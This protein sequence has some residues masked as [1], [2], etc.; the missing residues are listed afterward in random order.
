MVCPE[1]VCS[2]NDERANF[3]FSVPK[4][5]QTS[6]QESQA[7]LASYLL[8]LKISE[9]GETDDARFKTPSL[10]LGPRRAIR[11]QLGTNIGDIRH[12]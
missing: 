2:G 4:N 7:W 1:I 6:T 12:C 5:G 9:K 8:L 3:V 10:L 11:M